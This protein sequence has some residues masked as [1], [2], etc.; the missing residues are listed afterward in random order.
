MPPG[1]TTPPGPARAARPD[2]ARRCDQAAR[3]RR[4]FRGWIVIFLARDR[5]YKAYRRMPGARRDTALA[6]AMP[7]ALAAQ[8]TQAEQ[9]T[10]R[11]VCGLHDLAGGVPAWRGVSLGVSAR[12]ALGVRRGQ[13]NHPPMSRA[14]P[15]RSR[16]TPVSPRNLK[17]RRMSAE[18]ACASGNDAR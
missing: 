18:A 2:D 12:A 10:P 16:H 1:T 13:L 4:E 17:R 3:L 11:L 6:A 8:I 7:E 14:A 9:A 15:I 5:R